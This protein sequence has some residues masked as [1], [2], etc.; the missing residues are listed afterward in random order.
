MKTHIVNRLSVP[1]N[2]QQFYQSLFA[3]PEKRLRH[4]L[5]NQFIA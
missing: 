1:L 5:R 2:F 4:A 3:D